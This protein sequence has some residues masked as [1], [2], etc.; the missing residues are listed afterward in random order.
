MYH[1]SNFCDVAKRN[2]SYN[3]MTMDSARWNHL[4]HYRNGMHLNES[5]HPTT[6]IVQWEDSMGK[7]SFLNFHFFVSMERWNS[8]NFSVWKM[9]VNCEFCGVVDGT[10]CPLKVISWAVDVDVVLRCEYQIGDWIFFCSLLEFKIV[11]T[12]RFFFSKYLH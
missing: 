6:A 5:L 11:W 12:V 7:G 2:T 9:V 8:N 1:V 4:T 10:H 3:T